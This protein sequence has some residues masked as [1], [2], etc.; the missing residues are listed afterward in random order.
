VASS[1]LTAGERDELFIGSERP[2]TENS[3][4]AEVCRQA[5]LG[6]PLDRTRIH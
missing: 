6:H 4:L 2:V 3:E 1:K 5:S